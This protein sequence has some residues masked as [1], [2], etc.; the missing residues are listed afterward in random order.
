[1]YYLTNIINVVTIEDDS[2]KCLHWLIPHLYYSSGFYDKN[3]DSVASYSNGDVNIL[4]SCNEWSIKN[5]PIKM[6]NSSCM[7]LYLQ[8]LIAILHNCEALELNL[9]DFK[10]TVDDYLENFIKFFNS[11]ITLGFCLKKL[12]N[13]LL[14]D[15][16][17][18]VIKDMLYSFIQ[19]KNVLIVNAMSQLMKNQY[20]SGNLHKISCDF[21]IVNNIVAYKMPYTFFNDG[22][23]N[24]IHETVE[25]I[26]KDINDLDFD[27]AIVSAGA[28]SCLISNYIHNTMNKKIMIIGGN[29]LHLFGIITCRSKEQGLEFNNIEY[30]LSIPEDCKPIGYK[31]IERGCYW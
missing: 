17:Y 2:I 23:D 16:G 13:N 12:P 20:D 24:S 18:Y 15:N 22:P 30:W 7:Q 29:L 26:N 28:Y 5:N 21:P 25:N 19:N 14:M 9:F 11:N 10:N 31:N 8:K 6:F 4:I 27:C 3:L 1:M